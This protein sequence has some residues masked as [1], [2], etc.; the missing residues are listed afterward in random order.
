VEER[1]QW[2]RYGRDPAKV[3]F[4]TR[5][6]AVVGPG[7]LPADSE[8]HMLYA[9]RRVPVARAVAATVVVA[10]LMLAAG[11]AT[12]CSTGATRLGSQTGHELVA[13]HAPGGLSS[14]IAAVRGCGSVFAKGRVRE[15]GF[16]AIGPPPPPVRY[17]VVPLPAGPAGRRRASRWTEV[18]APPLSVSTVS[19]RLYALFLRSS[20]T[21]V[22]SFLMA[23]G[24][25]FCCQNSIWY[26]A[27]RLDRSN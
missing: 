15:V 14:R 6:A 8:P 7:R 1:C 26:A 25:D 9:G 16:S 5:P 19:T 21:D 13:K 18:R 24:S 11:S 4:R 23:G 27:V 20:G 22:T 17:S 10:V 3:V 2:E 12:L